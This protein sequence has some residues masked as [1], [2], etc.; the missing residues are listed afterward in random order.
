MTPEEQREDGAVYYDCK[1]EPHKSLM[2]KHDRNGGAPCEG[3]GKR[4]LTE[5]PSTFSPAGD[6]A[7][8]V[9]AVFEGFA[10]RQKSLRATRDTAAIQASNERL[11]EFP[12]RTRIGE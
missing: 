10:A 2:A 8:Y 6:A 3:S 11:K 7:D 9:R 1:P 4:L 5:S 12:V